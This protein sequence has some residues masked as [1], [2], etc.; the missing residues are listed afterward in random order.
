[1]L[2]FIEECGSRDSSDLIRNSKSL[3]EFGESGQAAGYADH[4]YLLLLLVNYRMAGADYR[5]VGALLLFPDA[6]A[7][8]RNRS[9]TILIIC[10]RQS[11]KD[12]KAL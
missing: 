6:V 9:C 12:L 7:H 5:G 3:L 8:G 1:M 11:M 2:A 10:V 4:P